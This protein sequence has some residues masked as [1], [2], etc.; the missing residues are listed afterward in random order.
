MTSAVPRARELAGQVLKLTEML[1]RGDLEAKVVDELGRF[2]NG[3]ATVVV[4]GEVKRGKSS[5]INALVE[6]P[7][8]LPVGVDVATNVRLA[9]GHRAEPCASVQTADGV[10]E[11]PIEELPRWA[12]EAGN[13]GNAAGVVSVAVGL[14]APV[15]A[16]GLI[17]MDTPGLNSRLPG[18]Q[19]V[20]LAALSA[21][22][23]VMMVIEPDTE[24]TSVELD[25]LRAATERVGTVLL[26]ATKADLPGATEALRITAAVIRRE[27]P[28]LRALHPLAVSAL[29]GELAG[30]QRA[31][32]DEAI[33]AVLD[34]D[35]GMATLRAVITSTIVANATRVRIANLM[36]VCTRV[37]EE[38]QK[39]QQSK[40]TTLEGPQA[41]ER[42]ANATR[43]ELTRLSVDE[44]QWRR[45]LATQMQRID[46]ETRT[47]VSRRFLDLRLRYTEE[48]TGST[49]GWDTEHLLEDLDRSLDALYAE[50]AGILTEQLAVAI[51]RVADVLDGQGITLDELRPAPALR[52]QLQAI[53][54]RPAPRESGG[55]RMLSYLPAIYAPAAIGSLAGAGA[56]LFGA[57]TAVVSA[58]LAPVAIPIMGGML[59]VRSRVSRRQAA[60]KHASEAMQEAL[61]VAKDGPDGLLAELGQTVARMGADLQQHVGERLAARRGAQE[62]LLAHQTELA[63]AGAAE[64]RAAVTE[65]QQELAMVRRVVAATSAEYAHLHATMSPVSTVAGGPNL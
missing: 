39:A 22:D 31:S 52:D 23:A 54:N 63:R 8:L 46:R 35:S 1:G 45:E 38:M 11:I 26:V 28:G 7:G 5:L 56:V 4:V 48:L 6:S 50:M 59:L 24:I 58:A 15:L 36:W 13:P 43:R 9:V 10:R 57:S 32:G 51:E 14:P 18:H 47:I 37:A 55:E 12:G 61:A 49:G 33:A 44:G 53:A 29:L 64:Q 60:R 20:A 16:H 27:I 62:D 41:A 19:A 17:L 25:F 3:V 30:R 34:A 65:L 42:E 40:L 2:K 21:M